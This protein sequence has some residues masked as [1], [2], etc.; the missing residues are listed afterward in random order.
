VGPHLGYSSAFG[1]EKALRSQAR[2]GRRHGLSLRDSASPR[3]ALGLK[4]PAAER[5]LGGRRRSYIL[6]RR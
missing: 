2:C 4:A 5:V 1:L 3:A 6:P